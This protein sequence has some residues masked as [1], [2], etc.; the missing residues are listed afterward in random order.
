VLLVGAEFPVVG[1]V[2]EHWCIDEAEMELLEFAPLEDVAV[3]EM[4]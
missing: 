2:T 1:V 3:Q 4:A